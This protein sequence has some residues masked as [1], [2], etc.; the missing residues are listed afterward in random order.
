MTRSAEGQKMHGGADGLQFPV[1]TEQL[2][3][4]A[5]NLTY[6]EEGSIQRII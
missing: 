3:Y 6:E 2:D 1:T 5:K 4:V